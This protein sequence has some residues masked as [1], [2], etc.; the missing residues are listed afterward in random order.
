MAAESLALKSVKC[1]SIYSGFVK[2]A[3]SPPVVELR[4]LGI[5]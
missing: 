4:S 5:S 1:G 3:L 2:Q